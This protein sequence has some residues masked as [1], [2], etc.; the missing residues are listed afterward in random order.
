[1]KFGKILFIC[2]FTWVSDLGFSQGQA[3]A[4]DQPF[5]F[6]APQHRSVKTVKKNHSLA[7]VLGKVNQFLRKAK[8][9]YRGKGKK[10]KR[11][12]IQIPFSPGMNRGL[13]RKIVK[14]KVVYYR[15]PQHKDRVQALD[16]EDVDM[17][18][19][20]R[21]MATYEPL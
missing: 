13:K 19:H 4:N 15:P 17:K 16:E 9:W 8:S 20:E 14:N 18:E 21:F 3:Q 12:A 11:L 6:F 2:L 5:L 7:G 10:G 1:M